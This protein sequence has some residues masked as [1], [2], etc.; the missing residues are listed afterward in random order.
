M[1]DVASEYIELNEDATK[2]IEREI[3]SNKG[4]GG[5]IYYPCGRVVKG[6][7]LQVASIPVDAEVAVAW[8]K[9][10]GNICTF[11]EDDAMGILE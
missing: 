3:Y 5:N 2:E 7:R 9:L 8:I 1:A 4:V 6:E 10:G 11:F